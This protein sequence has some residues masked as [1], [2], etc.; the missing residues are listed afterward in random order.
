MKIIEIIYLL[1]NTNSR[2][3]KEKILKENDSSLLRKIFYYAYEP[4]KV[5]YVQNIESIIFNG[6]EFEIENIEHALFSLLDKLSSREI[7]GNAAKEHIIKMGSNTNASTFEIIENILQKDLKCGI[8]EK[9]IRKVFGEKFITDFEVQLAN[10]YEEDKEYKVNSWIATPKLDGLRGVMNNGVLLSRNGKYLHGF[11]HI[12]E[13]LNFLKNK[14]DIRLFDGEMYSRNIPF[15]KIQS[16]VLSE[17]TFEYKDQIKYYIFAIDLLDKKFK[18][19]ESMYAAM[20]KIQENNELNFISFIPGI[21]IKNEN[22]EIFRVTNTYMDMGY[23]GSILRHPDIYIVKGR[24]DNLLKVKLRMKEVNLKIIDVIEGKN[25]YKG[26]MGA[27]LCKGIAEGQNI[28]VEVGSGFSDSERSK[29]F[30]NPEKFKNEII[31]VKY[32]NLTDE[33]NSL[34]FPRKVLFK[35]DR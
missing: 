28:E 14:Y 22:E 26:K 11:N 17:K 6:N 19:T 23:E 35:Q 27:L 30:D 7:T 33:K 12:E 1:K 13:E 16:I 31:T 5:F 2:L 15:Q 20:A 32:Q 8:G 18:N 9:T 34:R 29:I 21:K 4:L 24:T 3:E 25:K 10:K